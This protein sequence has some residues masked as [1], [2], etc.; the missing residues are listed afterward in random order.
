MSDAK[1]A[2]GR[3]PASQLRSPWRNPRV[4]GVLGL[5]FVAGGLC[6]GVV[7]RSLASSPTKPASSFNEVA[8]PKL[9]ER[10]RSELS[11]T[12][13]QDERITLILEDYSKFYGS[14]Q[15]QYSELQMQMGDVKAHLRSRIQSVLDERQ[16][17]RFEEMFGD[18]R[19]R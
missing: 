11:L 1:P 12:P 19:R 4:L 17:K 7:G 13:A 16:Q 15:E 18:A 14:L 10:L 2:D 9:R 8:K 5:V 6:G 3:H